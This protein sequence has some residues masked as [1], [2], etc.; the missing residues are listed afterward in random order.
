MASGRKFRVKWFRLAVMM[1]VGYCLYV[2]AGQQLELNAVNREAEATR[3][4]VEQLKQLNK[5][6]AEEKVRLS[7]PA[8]VERLARDELGLAKPGE[9]PYVPAEKK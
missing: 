3:G 8:Y 2:L 5:S 1:T 6:Y 7:T 4:R 9:V